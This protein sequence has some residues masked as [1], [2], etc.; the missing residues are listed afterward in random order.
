M[1]NRSAGETVAVLTGLSNS[2]GI[3]PTT[4]AGAYTLNVAGALTNPNY[5]V[6]TLNS[7]AWTVNP[8]SLTVSIIGDPTKV[9]DGGTGALGSRP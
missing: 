1:R 2:F 4:D 7:G 9:Y 6:T 3:V 5:T 8:A